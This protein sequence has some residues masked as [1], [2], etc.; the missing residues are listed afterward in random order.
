MKPGGVYIY[1]GPGEV[2]EEHRNSEELQ[3]NL[4]SFSPLNLIV[5]I[6]AL[7]AANRSAGRESRRGSASLI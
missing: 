6:V 5:K 7:I 3:E 4:G 2:T 1:R